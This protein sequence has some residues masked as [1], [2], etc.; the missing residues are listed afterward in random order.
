MPKVRREFRLLQKQTKRRPYVRS[1]F[2]G[3]EKIFFDYFWIHLNQKDAHDRARRL[4]YFPCA[5]ELLR[6]CRQAPQTFIKTAELHIIRHQFIG[7]ASDGSKFAVVIKEER[8][9]GKKNLLSLFP[10]AK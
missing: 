10:I 6:L 3:K 9:S 5:I 4:K 2:F 8:P 7:L 1:A